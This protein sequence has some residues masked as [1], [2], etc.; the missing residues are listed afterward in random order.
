MEIVF[1]A[2]NRRASP[3][4]PTQPRPPSPA[5]L[6]PPSPARPAATGQAESVV[7][8]GADGLGRANWRPTNAAVLRAGNLMAFARTPPEYKE[9]Q[10]FLYASFSCLTSHSLPSFPLPQTH[11]RNVGDEYVTE[12]ANFHPFFSTGKGGNGHTHST[13]H[14]RAPN[15]PPNALLVYYSCTTQY[16]K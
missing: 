3:S 16:P 10:C 8:Y 5:Q 2:S 9:K 15:Y 13:P 4:R 12:I 1:L 7:I 14:H 6:S 11:R